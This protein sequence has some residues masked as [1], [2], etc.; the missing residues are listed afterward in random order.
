MCS[1]IYTLFSVKA[2][3]SLNHQPHHIIAKINH[4]WIK[5]RRKRLF[6]FE[7]NLLFNTH[8]LIRTSAYHTN[9]HI[10]RE[11]KNCIQ[12]KV[13]FFFCNLPSHII[14]LK[15]F[16]IRKY[17]LGYLRINSVKKK[18]NFSNKSSQPSSFF[19][20]SICFFRKCIYVWQE[21]NW[22]EKKKLIRV[23]ILI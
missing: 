10:R 12:E 3:F 19:I 4:F 13:Y 23:Y 6:Q 8:K 20:Y 1:I 15:K 16:F 21:K 7:G 2:V 22:K 18:I 5:K 9:I 11:K 17:N 14:S